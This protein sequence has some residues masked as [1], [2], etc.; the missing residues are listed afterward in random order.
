[1]AEILAELDVPDSE[2]PDTWL[3]HHESG[4]SLIA[5]E[6]GILILEN[7][8]IG[9][10]PRHMANV[11]RSRVLQ[12]WQSLA[13]GDVEAIEREPWH[14]GHGISP[15]TELQR[16]EIDA[17]GKAMDREFYDSL[18]KERADVRCRAPNCARGA[19][20]ASAFCRVHHFEQINGRPSPFTH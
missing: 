20:A 8:D 14:P 19:V 6:Q 10:E 3:T 13:R 15:L 17:S 9:E 2:H 12:L 7:L 1:M 18:G 4:W 5:H 11:P 16:R